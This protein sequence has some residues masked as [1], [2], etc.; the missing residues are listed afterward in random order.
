M[1]VVD[2]NSAEL[3]NA[4]ADP[5]VLNDAINW[6]GRLRIKSATIESA[7]GDT[8]A[9]IYRF[10][11]VRSTD[12]IKSIQCMHDDIANGSDYDCGLWT[13]NGGAAV[14]SDLYCNGVTLA[15]AVPTI[16]HLLATSA[17]NELR[18]ADVTTA[19]INDVNN[20]VWEDLGLS[21]DSGLEYD[22]GLIGNT[23]GDG[24]TINL[25]MI[26]TAGD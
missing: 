2:L 21:A 22:L 23:V 15:V 26:Y 1:A 20:R 10:F 13:I 25:M 4:N 11:R 24:G 6:G 19:A 14:D 8:D 17:Y 16:P 12:S 9:S 3:T 18:F 7:S 5:R